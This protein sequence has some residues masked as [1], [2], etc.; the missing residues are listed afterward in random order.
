MKN[1]VILGGGESGYGT[2]ILAKKEGYNVFLSDRGELAP[3]YREGLV[4]AG[5]DF[6]EGEH[7]MAKILSANIVVKSPGIPEKA[8]VIRLLRAANIDVVSEMEFACKFTKAKI[9]S[10]TGSNGKTTTATLTHK[11][12]KE[13]GVNV[14][15]AGNIGDSFAYNVATENP[16]WYVLELSSFQLDGC[17]HFKSD[18][19][20]LNNVTPDHLDRYQ[21]DM[22][23]YV[24]SKF[25]V[26]QNQTEADYFIY[27]AADAH[28]KSYMLTPTAPINASKF[29]IYT[30]SVE[31]KEGGFIS[32]DKRYIICRYKKEEVK[33]D[34]QELK[35]SGLHNYANI[36][37]SV[38]AALIVDVN[39]NSIVKSVL[40]FGGVEHRLEAAGSVDGVVYI[41]DSKATNVDSAWYALDSMKNP[42]V[43]IAGGIDKGNDYS[44]LFDVAG[45][46]VHTLICMGVDNT[47][48]KDS[49]AGIIPNIIDANSLDMAFNAAVKSSK[50]G[51][52]VLLSPCCASFDLFKSYEDRGR[53]FKAEVEKL[54]K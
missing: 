12:L 8:D 5:I 10:I 29:P 52:V 40:S 20:I 19:A 28:T 25:R 11:I 35:V 42:T 39:T 22:N 34:T 15:L 50:K 41:N 46:N 9:I 44:Q 33:I 13:G 49:F 54:K 47:K 27:T 53:Q 1:I 21:Y 31:V 4:A 43:W 37:D 7:T 3:K 17:Y 45:K 51:D 30:S 24:N 14:A 48:L 16:D 18:I 6:E 32:E 26:C 38:L 2:A 36:M 23:L